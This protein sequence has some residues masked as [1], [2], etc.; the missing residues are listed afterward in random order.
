MKKKTI[1][2]QKSN[3]F[4]EGKTIEDYAYFIH[5][6]VNYKKYYFI[7]KSK[8][9]DQKSYLILPVILP[10]LNLENSFEFNL[11]KLENV[12]GF[13]QLKT[14]YLTQPHNFVST[15]K[16]A[17][18]EEIEFIFNSY[19]IDVTMIE[20]RQVEQLREP[21]FEYLWISEEE[22]DNH[23]CSD[24][25]VYSGLVFCYTKFLLNETST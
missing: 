13:H 25:I 19:S 6:T 5:K 11:E 2:L 3:Y 16:Y 22:L 14:F 15:G 8:N 21:Y 9:V 4:Q 1:S 17:E 10:K 7:K 20:Q 24:E 23:I 18:T 12:F